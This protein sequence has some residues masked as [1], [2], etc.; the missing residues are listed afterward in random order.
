MLVSAKKLNETEIGDSFRVRVSMTVEQYG[1]KSIITKSFLAK[2]E[3][4]N[5]CST[6]S[7]MIEGI[8]ELR[9]DLYTHRLPNGNVFV[10]ANVPVIDS[11]A[12]EEAIVGSTECADWLRG[13]GVVIEPTMLWFSQVVRDVQRADEIRTVETG[14]SLTAS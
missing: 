11:G 8:E 7:F 9:P 3:K 13:E 4:A 6:S 10:E 12:V 2:K 14:R 5:E 1:E